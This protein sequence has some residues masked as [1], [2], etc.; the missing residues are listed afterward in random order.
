ML[1]MASGNAPASSTRPILKI[2]NPENRGQSGFLREQGNEQHD[3]AF[4]SDIAE[5]STVAYNS[6][7]AVQKLLRNSS[8]TL[9]LAGS[10]DMATQASTLTNGFESHHPGLAETTNSLDPAE[11]TTSKQR[12]SHALTPPF[13]SE[14]L[15]FCRK[16]IYT[17]N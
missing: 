16:T 17:L 13:T 14:Y 11:A 3:L 5:L 4:S 8:G 9:A 6:F 15:L 7:H 2:G 12:E 1:G 10:L